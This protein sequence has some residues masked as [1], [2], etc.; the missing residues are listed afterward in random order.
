MFLFRA[1]QICHSLHF[2]LLLCVHVALMGALVSNL[3]VL[4]HD[5]TELKVKGSGTLELIHD[6]HN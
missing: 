5:T 2:P 6:R 3:Y 1:R 4:H